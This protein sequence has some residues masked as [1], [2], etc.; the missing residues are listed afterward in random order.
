VAQKLVLLGILVLAGL[1]ARALLCQWRPAAGNL[2]GVAAV[3]AAIWNPFVA[4]RLVIGQWTVLLGYAVLP[5]VVRAAARVRAGRGS[6]GALVGWVAVGSLGGANSWLLVVPPAL[7]LLLLPR[8]VWRPTGAVVATALGMAAAWALP[9]LTAGERG[10]PSGF[11]AFGARADTPLGLLI[12]LLAGGGLWNPA[13]HPPERAVGVLAA[14]SAA[15]LCAGVA[16][17]LLDRVKAPAPGDATR[18]VVTALGLTGVLL[19]LASGT[20]S[21]ARVWVMLGEVPGGA[22]LRDGQ[23]LLAWWV[24]AGAVGVGVLADRLSVRRGA[25]AALGAALALAFPLAMP[26]LAWGVQGRLAAVEVPEDLRYVATTLSTAEQGDVGLLPWRQYR[27][28]DW[29]ADR[30]SLSLVPRMVARPVVFDDSLPLSRGRVRGEDER[31]AR[32]TA[33]I[34]SGTDPFVALTSAGVRYVVVER[35]AGLEA[36][37]PPTDARVLADGPSA[38]LLDLGPSTAHVPDH[39]PAVSAWGWGITSV[40]LIAVLGASIGRVL[41]RIIRTGQNSLVGFAP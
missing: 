31:A 10:D 22:L 13:S 23:K 12:S 19:A 27:R 6:T 20:S 39:R 25:G 21:L 26:S 35:R 33:A 24:L 32:V 29:N 4:E 18:L 17:L 5:W 16:A 37:V 38:L 2:A 30:V 3:V 40:T 14:L 7:L 28:Y 41:R 11:A 9:A 36:P 1:G 34:E 15:L 8:P